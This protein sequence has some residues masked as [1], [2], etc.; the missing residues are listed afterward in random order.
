MLIPYL[1]PI[2]KRNLFYIAII[3]SLGFACN[4]DRRNIKDY[5][6][7]V[8]DL[9]K[10][11]VY[12]YELNVNGEKTTDYWYL[13][14]FVRDSGLY[15]ASTN[16]D[17]QFHIN[18]IVREKMT[19]N[20]AI[21][22]SYYV[23]EQD[24]ATQ[25]A[26]QTEAV[27]KSP[28][29][30]PFSVKDSLGVFLFSLHYSPMGEIQSKIYL[31]RNRRYLGDGPNFEWNGKKYAT[32]RMGIR[33]AIGNEGEGA[34]EIEGVGEEWYAKGIGLVYF[35]KK[36]GDKGALIREYRLKEIISMDQLIQRAGTH[37]KG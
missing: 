34:A 20:G 18:Q 33:E 5:Y 23:Y 28:D 17:N 26:I 27:L 7:P 22:R 4:S 3:V 11:S 8:L 19:E 1:C 31:I 30:F 14:G 13:M 9:Q 25:K 32:I 2:M 6:Y 12:C 21:A 37:W 16:Y 29:I 24:S 10:G 35:K 36:Y 15:L